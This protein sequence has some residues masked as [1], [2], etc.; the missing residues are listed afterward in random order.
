MFSPNLYVS[1]IVLA[2]GSSLIP[3]LLQGF[4]RMMQHQ[5]RP[6]NQPVPG[7]Q[8]HSVPWKHSS[9]FQHR[10]ISPHHVW[11]QQIHL[12][13]DGALEKEHKLLAGCPVWLYMNVVL[14]VHVTA[15]GAGA[16][17]KKKNYSFA[18]KSTSEQGNSIKHWPKPT[19]LKIIKPWQRHS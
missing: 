1:C 2:D 16:G 7:S 15:P 4:F 14:P 8:P 17:K 9:L 3:A 19:F 10:W 6:E 18:M 5:E 11:A 13:L 12:S